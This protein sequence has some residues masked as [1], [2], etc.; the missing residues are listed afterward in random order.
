MGTNIS[1]V[2]EFILPSLVAQGY[3]YFDNEHSKTLTVCKGDRGTTTS[4]YARLARVTG[5]S[6]SDESQ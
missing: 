3:I 6:A 1:S 5:G 2:V 4:L